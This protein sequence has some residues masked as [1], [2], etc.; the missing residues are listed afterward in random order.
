MAQLPRNHAA[1][2]TGRREPI[3][4]KVEIKVFRLICAKP[5]LR[6]ARIDKHGSTSQRLVPVDLCF[7]A[8]PLAIV[9]KKSHDALIGASRVVCAHLCHYAAP[10][11]FLVGRIK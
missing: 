10:G 5:T 9:I 6:C 7:E 1:H 2:R 4:E 11:P 8:S 3:K